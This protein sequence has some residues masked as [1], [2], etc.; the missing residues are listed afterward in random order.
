MLFIV[1]LNMPYVFVPG[2]SAVPLRVVS[3]LQ[4]LSVLQRL[5]SNPIT[6][7][8]LPGFFHLHAKYSMPLIIFNV[9]KF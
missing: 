3:A 1:F 7:S 9:Y 2:P 6:T 5:T 4:F 8:Q